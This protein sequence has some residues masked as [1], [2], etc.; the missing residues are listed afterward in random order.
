MRVVRVAGILIAWAAVIR[1]VTQG[2]QG[3]HTIGECGRAG[4]VTMHKD[5]CR[6]VYRD[7]RAACV[8]H[9][10]HREGRVLASWLLG[11]RSSALAASPVLSR[12]VILSMFLPR[13]GH[14]NPLPQRDNQHWLHAGARQDEVLHVP[15]RV[16]GAHV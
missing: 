10:E 16:H 5:A 13:Y 4:A 3:S 6:L 11:A 2:E 14:V 1:S 9:I 12:F 8:E 7:E 15:H